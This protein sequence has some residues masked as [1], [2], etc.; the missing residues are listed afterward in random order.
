MKTGGGRDRRP[1][2]PATGGA[3]LFTQLA[4]DAGWDVQVD[5][6]AN[7]S[8]PGVWAGRR[9]DAAHGSHLRMVCPTAALTTA[10][11][12]MAG[13]EVLLTV[14]DAG[15]QLPFHLEVVDFTADEEALAISSAAALA[16]AHTDATLELFFNRSAS[17]LTVTWTSP[18][19]HRHADRGD[20]TDSLARLRPCWPATWNSTLSRAAAGNTRAPIGVV[21]AIFGRRSFKV[22]FRGRPDHAGTTPLPP[23]PTCWSPPPSLGSALQLV[24]QEFPMRRSPRRHAGR[25]PGV[26]NVVPDNV[27]LLLE[28]RAVTAAEPRRHRD[29]TAWPAAEIS[30]YPASATLWQPT[31]QHLPVPMHTGMQDAICA[32]AAK[33][34][35]WCPWT[36]RPA[37]ATT[38]CSW[39]RSYPRACSSPRP[40]AAA[41]IAPTRI[42]GR[43]TWSRPRRCCW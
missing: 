10:L 18:I 42:P 4:E 6:A 33:Q 16:G 35:Y 40:S 37:R 22:T 8:A 15:A 12:V 1:F 41:A 34:G 7:L 43:T 30:A 38:H 36:S 27:T 2:S 25:F 21:S 17:P 29:C 5:A 14:A 26:Y 31:S 24:G 23:A 32:A 20:G 19:F 11:G 28:F 3:P 13:L 39:P 9:Q